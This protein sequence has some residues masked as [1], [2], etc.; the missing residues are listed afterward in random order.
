MDQ[1]SRLRYSPGK[2]YPYGYSPGNRPKTRTPIESEACLRVKIK[3]NMKQQL[4][5]YLLPDRPIAFN[6]DFVR[7]GCGV[8]GA[9]MLSQ[10]VYWC[11]RTD[12]ED[13]SFW[14]TQEEWE[15]ET[16]LTRNEQMT[17]LKLLKKLGYLKVEKKGLPAKNYYIVDVNKILEG[18]NADH[19]WSGKSTTSGRQT[20]TTSGRESRP[21]SNTESTT[22]ITSDIVNP[23]KQKTE[24]FIKEVHEV[25]EGIEL[26]ENQ[27]REV[28]KFIS[29]WTEPTKNK[30]KIK[31]DRE[32]T[33]DTK[34]RLGTWMRNSIK[35]SNSDN[36]PKGIRI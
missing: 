16:G 20:N 24:K 25:L 23:I 26:N 19:Q 3:K 9:L 29:Y 27:K 28:Q 33:W 5:A 4:P 35:W 1:E 12:A 18:L 11:R 8:K 13:G 6:R 36:Q 15:E 7:I 14:K 10:A 17:V 21:H 34:R 30:K 22:E 32:P 31:Y 2:P